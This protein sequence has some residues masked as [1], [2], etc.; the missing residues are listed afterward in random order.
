MTPRTRR[1]VLAG[2]ASLAATIAATLAG[3][4]ASQAD[5][6][7]ADAAAVARVQSWLDT[8][9][10]LR[11]RFL[12][13]WP[14][15]AVSEGTVLFA[16]PGR[17]RLDYAPHDRM[18]LVASGGHIVL[19][20]NTTGAVTRT[21]ARANPLGLL[22]EPHVTLLGGAVR[23]TDVRQSPGRLQ[24]SLDRADNPLAGL[25]TL[26][27]DDQ[28]G[29]LTLVS[30]QGLDGEHRRTIFRLFDQTEDAAIPPGLFALPA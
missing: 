10:G 21:P 25:L 2:A 3:C 12:Q 14:D 5:L 26:V 6:A 30:L 29:H 28:A 19:T 1:L 22:L 4:A 27:F 18:V 15:G 13:T 24:L 8:L 23:V 16:P 11:A 17:L 9:P 7:P 20:D